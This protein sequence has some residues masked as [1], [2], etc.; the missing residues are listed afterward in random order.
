MNTINGVKWMR[1]IEPK[2]VE[3]IND[4]LFN[5]YFILLFFYLTL[6]LTRSALQPILYI[7]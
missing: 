7:I 4:H 3:Q 5:L 2:K 1:F 6:F